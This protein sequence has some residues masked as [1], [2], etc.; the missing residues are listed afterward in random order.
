MW[1]VFAYDKLMERDKNAYGHAL[2][3]C[4]DLVVRWS[5]IDQFKCTDV[6]SNHVVVVDECDS[7]ILDPKHMQQ[8]HEAL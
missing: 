7:L 8:T 4:N 2:G 1:L 6:K 3:A 5:T